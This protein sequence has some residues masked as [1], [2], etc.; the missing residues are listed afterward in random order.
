[1]FSFFVLLQLYQKH[2]KVRKKVYLMAVSAILPVYNSQ[3]TVSDCISSLLRQTKKPA[4][5]IVVDDGSKDSTVGIVKKFRGVKLIQLKKTLGRSAARNAGLKKAKSGT[6]FFAEADAVYDKNFL[7]ECEKK[8]KG[9]IGGVIGKQEVWNADESAWAKCKAAE[10][11]SAFSDYRPFTGWMYPRELLLELG[12]FDKSLDFGEDVDLARRFKAKGFG[13]A[14]AKKAVWKHREPASL[15]ALCAR[16]W[17]FGLGIKPFYKKNGWPRMIFFDIAFFL[18]LIAGFFLS[19]AWFY[20]A[21][22]LLGK[23][24]LARRV[25][26][27][28]S[29]ALWPALTV[30]VLVPSLFF[31][32]G[33]IIGLVK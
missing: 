29:P 17:R 7:E 23:I 33:R 27:F 13:F 12:G 11:E 30:F 15:S 32:L 18:S 3:E 5:L 10:R 28:A 4:E 25:F 8:L 22:F 21:G 16:Q 19:W 2:L 9:K 6:V 24:F 1:M 14:L 31:K 20:S 26:S